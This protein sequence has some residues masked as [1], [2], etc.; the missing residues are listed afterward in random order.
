MLLARSWT[1][2]VLTGVRRHLARITRYQRLHE[3]LRQ[4]FCRRNLRLVVIIAKK[5]RHRGLSYLDL[6]QEGNTG[7]MRAVDKFEHKRGYKFSTYAFWWIRQA[8]TRAIALNSRTVRVPAQVTAHMA[9]IQQATEELAQSTGRWPTFDA[10]ARSAGLSEEATARAIRCGRALSLDQ[11][12]LCDE[13]CARAELLQDPNEDDVI[14]K[15]N[16]ELLK[17][18]I[19][20]AMDILNFQEREVLRLRYGLG[21]NNGRT[22]QEIGTLFR[23]TRERV[24]QIETKALVK[25]RKPRASRRLFGFV[26]DKAPAA[27]ANQETEMVGSLV[28]SRA[29]A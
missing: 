28:P 8:I 15:L 23:V 16:D 13:K 17:E 2:Y 27:G 14:E 9:T 21:S 20:E 25:L 18:R 3:D 24:R 6:I 4:E 7:L 12:T 5:D 19:D 22:L 1:G 11:P 10:I 26:E 29:S